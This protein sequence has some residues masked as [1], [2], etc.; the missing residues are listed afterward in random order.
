MTWADD[1]DNAIDRLLDREIDLIFSRE[2]SFLAKKVVYALKNFR[3]LYVFSIAEKLTANKTRLLASIE[4]DILD[5][6]EYMY[7]VF[8]E[9]ADIKSYGIDWPELTEI[10]EKH[11]TQIVKVL[12]NKYKNF[13]KKS[14]IIPFVKTLRLI[15]IDWLE[16]AAIEK[17]ANAV[18]TESDNKITPQER[19]VIDK[20][21]PGT[22]YVAIA[23]LSTWPTPSSAIRAALEKQKTRLLAYLTEAIMKNNFSTFFKAVRAFRTQ[24]IDWPELDDLVEV[25]KRPLIVKLLTKLKNHEDS[26]DLIYIETIIKDASRVVAWP[27]LSVI[28][29]HADAELDLARDQGIFGYEPDPFDDEMRG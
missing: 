15:G 13:Y 19:Y 22:Y 27:E 5:G 7:G 11:K 21:W 29:G 23:S 16:L 25:S 6:S 8:Q 24:Q 1:T 17:S 2:Q 26:T 14:D 28:K 12:L 10:L 18:I 20:L 4:R 9:I 3:T